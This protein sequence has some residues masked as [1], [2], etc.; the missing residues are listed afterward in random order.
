MKL[1]VILTILLAVFFVSSLACSYS[2]KL[3]KGNEVVA[4]VESF[5]K[6]KGRLPNS[7]SEIGIEETESGPIYYRKESESK[8]TVWFGKELGE[9]A[10]YDSETKEWSNL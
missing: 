3:A 10:T 4:K 6:D 5:R 2:E 8:Y 1:K 9:S 7:L